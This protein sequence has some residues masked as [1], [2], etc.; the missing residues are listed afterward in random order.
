MEAEPAKKEESEDQYEQE[1]FALPDD[2][3][4]GEDDEYTMEESGS[5]ET[6]QK[7][8]TNE[9]EQKNVFMKVRQ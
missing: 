8:S 5:K 7:P 1:E 3:D 9:Q 6:S 2:N 4:E